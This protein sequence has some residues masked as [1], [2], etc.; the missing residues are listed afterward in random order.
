MKTETK[1]K[2]TYK[3]NEEL[4]S[5]KNDPFVKK[6]ERR[7]KNILASVKPKS[8]ERTGDTTRSAS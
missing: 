1:E 8:S 7:A 2:L 6:K 5:H 4:K 3:V